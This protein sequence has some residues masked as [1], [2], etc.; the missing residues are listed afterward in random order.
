MYCPNCGTENLE[1]INFCRSCGLDL[2]TIARVMEKHLPHAVL[3]KIDDKILN[4]K[5]NNLYA[6]VLNLS[7]SVALLIFAILLSSRNYPR[8]A[9]YFYIGS[10]FGFV[11]TIWYFLIYIRSRSKTKM[12]LTTGDYIEQNR[13]SDEESEKLKSASAKELTTAKFPV[14]G[15][16]ENTT[17]LLSADKYEKTE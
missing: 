10:F 7:A 14:S 16:T 5:K 2:S 9:L 15:V 4:P 8:D 1:N 11:G 17:N 3:E 6:S 13:L 12:V